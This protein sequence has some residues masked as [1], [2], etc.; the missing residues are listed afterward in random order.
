MNASFIRDAEAELRT[1]YYQRLPRSAVLGEQGHSP[2]AGDTT[3]DSWRVSP[4]APVFVRA[5]GALKWDV[6]GRAYVDLWMGHGALL[7]GHGHPAVVDAL[8]EQARRG[9]HL[10]GSSSALLEQAECVQR[11]VPSIERLRFT[12]SGTEATLLALRVARAYTGRAIVIRLDGH[13]HGWHDEAMTGLFAPATSGINAFVDEGVRIASPFDAESVADELEHGDV[14]AVILEPGG[15][16]GGT[17]P[18]DVPFLKDLRR[19]TRAR[20]T[21]LVFDEVMSGF[22]YAPGGAQA[23]ADVEPDLTVLAKIL[24]GGLPG[25]ALGGRREIMAVFGDG[26][27]RPHGLAKVMHSGTFNGNPLAAAAGVATLRHVA[28]GQPQRTAAAAAQRLV[29]AIDLAA[30]RAAVDV[31][32]FAQS[33]IVHLMIGAIAEGVPAEPSTAG[34]ILRRKHAQRHALLRLALLVEGI[35]GHASH[36]WLSTAHDDVV[37]AHL[38]EGFERAF[39][40]LHDIPG[41]GEP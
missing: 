37:I 38:A 34:L 36:G 20:G 5:E 35:D 8:R 31:R 1:A 15:G 2:V 3:H 23:L 39:G 25:A 12:S 26:C 7:L 27:E 9:L 24:C 29:E 33:S 41:F 4:F 14:A 30:T 10:S 19:L 21:L 6:D 17:L 11:L 40:R 13:F 28:D 16:S 32:A 18:F 22:R